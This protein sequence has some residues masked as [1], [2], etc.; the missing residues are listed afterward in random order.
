MYFCNELSLKYFNLSLTFQSFHKYIL[1]KIFKGV[2]VMIKNNLSVSSIKSQKTKNGYNRQFLRFISLPVFI[3][4]FLLSISFSLG[5][6]ADEKSKKESQKNNEVIQPNSAEFRAVWVT[7]F[8]WTSKDPQECKDKIINIFE[9]LKNNNFNTAVFQIRGEAEVLYRSQYEPWSP[10]LDGKDPGFDPLEFAIAEAHKR[11]IKFHAYIN[12]IPLSSSKT[13][14]KIPHTN[15]E[16]LFHLH[17]PD[18][19]EPWICMTKDKKPMDAAKAEYYYLSPGIPKVQAYLRMVIMDVVKRY[20]VDGIHLDRIRY[21]GPEYSYDEVSRE[22]FFGRGNPTKLEWTDWQRE[23]LNKFIND[24]AAEMF[25][26]KPNIVFSCAAWGIYNRHNI[27]GYDKFSSGYHDYFQDTWEWIKLGA[28]DVLMPMIYWNIPD[29]K[30]NYN[31]LMDDF[32]KGIGAEHLVGGQRTFGPEENAEEVKYSRQ[33]GA[34][35]TVLFAYNSAKRRGIY[36]VFKESIYKESVPTPELDWKKNPKYGTILGKVTDEDGNPL[37]DAWV[38]ISNNSKDDKMR[39]ERVFSKKWTSGSDGRFAFLKIPPCSVTIAVEYDGA[40]KI[41]SEV[42]DIKAGETKEVNIK[43]KG[44]KEAESQTFFHIFQPADGSDTDRDVCHILGR[45]LP[46]NKITINNEEVTVYPT[47]GGFA[48]DN[49]PLAMGMNKIEIKATSPNNQT[50]TRYLTVNRVEP[51]QRTKEI[52]GVEVLQPVFD[53]A[54][55]PGDV[56]EISAKAPSGMIGAAYCFNKRVIIPLT[57]QLDEDTTPTGT[58][59]ANVKIPAFFRVDPSPVYFVFK[60]DKKFKMFRKSLKAV[61]KGKIEVWSQTKVRVGETIKDKTPITFG[62]HVVRLGGPYLCEVPI[63]TRFEIIGKMS[64]KYKIKLAPNLSAWLPEENVKMLSKNTPIPHLFFTSISIGGDDKNDIVGIPASEKVIYALSVETEP[65]NCIYVDLF[66][67]HYAATWISHKTGAKNLGVITGEQIA[68]DWVRL[69][70]PVKSKQIWGFWA[71]RD[72]NALN[73]Y[74]KRPPKL[75]EPPD[76][77][78]KGLT[79]AIEAGHGGTGSGAVGTMGTKEKTINAMAVNLVK[80]ALEERGAKTVMMRI[81]DSNPS[82]SD[83]VD[84]AVQ[85]NADF[86]ITIHAN[87]AGSFRGFLK[88]SGTS[89]YFRYKH[90]YLPAKLVYDELLKLGWNEFGVVGNFHYYPLRDT[91]MPSFLVEQAFMDNPAD[92]AKLLD[93]QYQEEQTQAIIRGVENFLNMVRE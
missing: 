51:R 89:T 15:P 49:I 28:M 23:Q 78:L 60:P 14:D 41:Q 29:P 3:L 88:V 85:A 64:D 19:K 86:M 17:G 91:T 43:V 63:G 82:L 75:A 16:H 77:P 81:G 21:P 4:I 13:P 46:T 10:L 20:D 62:T 92:E 39:D 6:L 11:G 67:T 76:S 5:A 73:I 40:E 53:M 90:C 65:E 44:A 45:T 27:P 72:D 70:I 74:V 59:Y 8:E 36:E 66:N 32:A 71:Q 61:S 22:R 79:F 35:G 47:T 50:T 83:R 7:R 1:H 48:M 68:D 25:S 87:A 55:L 9:D 37:C 42:I 12:P 18:S 34:A 84:I 69:K 31:E 54:F 80:K 30:P 24:L 26:F 58:Y 93:E 56:L 2:T 38:S 57:E 33:I 52:T